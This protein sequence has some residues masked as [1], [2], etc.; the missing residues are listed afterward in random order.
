MTWRLKLHKLS[1][2][3]AT[4]VALGLS[5]RAL[6]EGFYEQLLDAPSVTEVLPCFS[7]RFA[8]Y[9][10]WQSFVVERSHHYDAESFERS[11]P[12]DQYSIYR[13]RLNCAFFTYTVDGLEIGGYAIASKHNGER[14]VIVV[15]RGGTG[16]FGNVKFASLFGRI[17]EF[18]M[19][20]YF[21]I[22]SQYRGGLGKAEEIGG[23]D[24]WGGSDVRDVVSLHHIIESM[25][26]ANAGLVGMFG[27]SRGTVNT[28][29]AIE[30]FPHVKAIVALGG[31]Y[32]LEHELSHRPRMNEVL[33]DHIP[34]LEQDRESELSKRSVVK[35]VDR[36]SRNIP[37]LLIHGGYDERATATGA[38]EFAQRLQ[39]RFHPYKLTIYERDDHF[40]SENS[41]SVDEEISQW[42]E[43]YIR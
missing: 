37:I 11:F 38:L 34:N 41:D 30:E 1:I 17:F 26:A 32:D 27:A 7:G 19:D 5:E 12:P 6:S 42:F 23:V 8:D 18:A 14:P 21:V 35:W 39:E 31:V 13:E 40:L 10:T 24:E 43:E 33:S 16:T 2:V 29:R 9:E 22:G 25:P 3:F 4:V 36:I 28:F 15:N 20:G